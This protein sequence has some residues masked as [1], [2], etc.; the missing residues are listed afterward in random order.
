[1][2]SQDTRVRLGAVASKAWP[3]FCG[4]GHCAAV[5]LAGCKST[6]ENRVA[7][8]FHGPRTNVLHGSLAARLPVQDAKVRQ[9][10]GTTS[11]CAGWTSH[12]ITTTMVFMAGIGEMWRGPEMMK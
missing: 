4:A 1:M 5:W 11:G 7:K 10:M 8:P 2:G 9:G 3:R 12:R 6:C